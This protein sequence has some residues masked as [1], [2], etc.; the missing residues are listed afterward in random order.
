MFYFCSMADGAAL[1]DLHTA[2]ARARRLLALLRELTEIGMDLAR[3]LSREPHGEVVTR[4]LRIAKAVRQL[5]A[6]EF[7]LTQ[8]L[9]DAASGRW[10]AAEAERQLR[11]IADE[12]RKAEAI[13]TLEAA[14]RE[15]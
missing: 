2:V 3:G 15:G 12:A 14:I 6:L 9:Q 4:Y 7:R 8:A 11:A 10:A 13:E 5:I 1:P